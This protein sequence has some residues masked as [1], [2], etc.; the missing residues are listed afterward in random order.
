MKEILE[1]LNIKKNFID[2]NRIIDVK[3]KKSIIL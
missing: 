2:F 1:T 3:V